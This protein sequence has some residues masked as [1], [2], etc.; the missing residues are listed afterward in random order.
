MTT[1]V[2]NTMIEV[3]GVPHKPYNKIPGEADF[4]SYVWIGEEYHG[5][6]K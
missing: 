5:T 3:S 4:T 2:L 1:Q 6:V